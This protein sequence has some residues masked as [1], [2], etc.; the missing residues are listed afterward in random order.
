MASHIDEYSDE[1][2]HDGFIYRHFSPWR[3]SSWHLWAALPIVAAIAVVLIFY[4][5]L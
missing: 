1:Y 2:S 5:V 4:A 3:P